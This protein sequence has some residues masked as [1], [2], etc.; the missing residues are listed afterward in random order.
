VIKPIPG[1]QTLWDSY[2]RVLGLIYRMV[3][4][5]FRAMTICAEATSK[6]LITGSFLEANMIQEYIPHEK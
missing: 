5:Q 1:Q 3:G 6:I 4:D 2:G